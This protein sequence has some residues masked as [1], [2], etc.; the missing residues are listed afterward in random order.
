MPKT[1]GTQTPEKDKI[2]IDALQEIISILAKN[3]RPDLINS[4][5][6]IIMENVNIIIDSDSE[7]E[8]DSTYEDE[9]EVGL[10][11]E[12]DGDGFYSLK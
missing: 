4:L 3:G 11:C 9:E 2:N 10:E 6:Q 7:S 12:I 5:K 8:S 1:K